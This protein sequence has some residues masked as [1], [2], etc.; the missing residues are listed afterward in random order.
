MN[1]LSFQELVSYLK[2]NVAQA[3]ET[4]KHLQT[5]SRCRA[6]LLLIQKATEA[7]DTNTPDS[8]VEPTPGLKRRALTAFQR[9]QRQNQDRVR[10]TATLKY[11]SRTKIVA[12]G[13]RGGR[14]TDR[15]LL[16]AINNGRYDVDFQ[17]AKDTSDTYVL[18]GQIMT[19]AIPEINL[20]GLELRCINADGLERRGLSDNL[21]RFTF[22]RL[23]QAIYAI[24][25][26]F[27]D[28]V[29]LFEAVEIKH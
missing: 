22:S 28:S 2:N 14:E 6:E 10:L 18:R 1:H 9:K 5:C 16:Y 4:E 29:V 8:L 24:Q 25:I 3:T 13:M 23:P 7:L 15:Q 27:D 17:I 11:D 26:T 19:G 12:A 20:E 21:G